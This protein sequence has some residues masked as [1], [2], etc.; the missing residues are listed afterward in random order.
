MRKISSGPEQRASPGALCPRG[1][2]AHP[3]GG[4]QR[5]APPPLLR[6]GRGL[7]SRWVLAFQKVPW[8]S[9]SA[10]VTGGDTGNEQ[11]RRGKRAVGTSGAGDPKP[12]PCGP[13]TGQR[14]AALR[15]RR[16]LPLLPPPPSSPDAPLRRGGA[17]WEGRD[18]APPPGRGGGRPRSPPS[19]APPPSGPGPQCS[20]L[21]PRGEGKPPASR[22]RPRGYW[23]WGREDLCLAR[24][25]PASRLTPWGPRR[26]KIKV[27]FYLVKHL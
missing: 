24:P 3:D 19:A 26:Q 14:A 4:S 23:G 9:P 8:E 18:M 15:S 11:L 20:P 17:G 7:G 10:E 2:S 27:L 22:D 5:A 16:R 1:R 25:D 13:R 21:L 12:L 6:V